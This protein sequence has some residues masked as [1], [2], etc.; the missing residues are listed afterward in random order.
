MD[1]ELPSHLTLPLDL[2][3]S[4]LSFDPGIQTSA[5]RD[6]SGAP[7]QP[8]LSMLSGV[9]EKFFRLGQARDAERLLRPALWDVLQRC[10]SDRHPSD[11]DVELAGQLAIRLA[12]A[13]RS[14]GWIDYLFRVFTA[15]SRP[16]SADVIEGLHDLMRRIQGVNHHGF[17]RY[18]SALRARRHEFGPGEHFLYRRIE[19]LEPLLLP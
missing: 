6:P 8:H 7:A 14:P 12:A 1:S 5:F 19:G 13:N 11:R 4:G 18:L 16:L 17:V 3:V 15:V 10:E 2:E 9:A